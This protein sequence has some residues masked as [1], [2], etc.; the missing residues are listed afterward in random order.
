VACL[1]YTGF[2]QFGSA[3]LVTYGSTKTKI[4]SKPTGVASVHR[5]RMSSRVM[6]E[7]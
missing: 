2:V 4:V 6:L 3:E 1:A 5:M 7:S